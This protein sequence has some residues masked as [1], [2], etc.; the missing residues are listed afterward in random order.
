MTRADSY[1]VGY[2][3]ATADFF[4]DRHAISHAAFFLRHLRPGMTVL[5]GGCGPGSITTDLTKIVSPGEVFGLDIE[6]SHINL[7][8]SRARELGVTN[9]RFECC[10]LYAIPFPND[11]FDAVFLHGVIEHLRNPGDALLEVHRVLK[12]GGLVGARHADIGGFI[13]EP[14]N[15]PLDRFAEFYERLLLHNGAH[16]HAGRQQ[17]RWLRDAGFTRTDVSA[18]YD[19]WTRNPDQTRV[20][21]DFL[22]NLVGDSSFAKQLIDAGIADRAI[23]EQMRL[24]FLRWGTNLDAFAAEAWGEAVAWKL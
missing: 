1:S 3:A 19:C 8:R 15:P 5:D 4:G 16:P 2:D 17:L 6:Q 24:D 11:S 14:A 23:L 21:A 18:S 9:I 13:F 10:S 7:A 22:A 20:T 12:R